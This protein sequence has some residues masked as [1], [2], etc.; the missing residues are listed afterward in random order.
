MDSRAARVLFQLMAKVMESPWRYRFSNP[1]AS[2]RI[3][4][5][6]PGQQVLEI[7]C[8]T[9]FYTIPQQNWWAK[10]ARCMLWTPIH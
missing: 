10:K 1:V 6:R 9:G 4:G 5:I 8:S 3:T 2:L 7:G